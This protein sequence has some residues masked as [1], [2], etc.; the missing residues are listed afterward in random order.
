MYIPRWQNSHASALLVFLLSLPGLAHAGC[1]PF[2]DANQHIGATRCITGKVL[3]VEKGDKGVTYLDFCE[4]HRT[5]PF[6]VVVFASDLKDVGDVRE[7]QGRTVEVHGEVKQYDGRA[8][9]ILSRARQLGGKDALPPPL[10]KK[11]TWNARD[12][13]ARGRSPTRKPP[14]RRTQKRS[15]PRPS[16]SS[17]PAIRRISRIDFRLEQ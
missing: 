17:T 14:A 11:T 7:L 9:I 8:E 12:G 13:I 3:R 5:C 10:P 15:S 2:T 4:D 6:N 1:I 16:P